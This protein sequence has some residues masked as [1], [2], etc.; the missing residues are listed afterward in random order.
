MPTT[1]IKTMA[2]I[3]D[4]A[5]EELI[6]AVCVNVLFVLTAAVNVWVET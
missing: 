1:D 4:M 5:Q 6:Y 2:T 3:E